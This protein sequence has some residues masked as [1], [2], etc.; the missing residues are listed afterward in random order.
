MVER[1][2][3]SDNP[4]LFS[5]RCV[6]IVYAA[7]F[8]TND[9]WWKLKHHRKQIAQWKGNKLAWGPNIYLP[10]LGPEK[11]VIVGNKSLLSTLGL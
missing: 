4:V 7:T 10:A 8:V 1:S 5:G 2:Q 11:N 9:H 3:S 6:C